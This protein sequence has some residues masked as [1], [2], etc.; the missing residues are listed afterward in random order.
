[1]WKHLH[2]IAVHPTRSVPVPGYNDPRAAIEREDA[3]GDRMHSQAPIDA[4]QKKPLSISTYSGAVLISIPGA[5][6]P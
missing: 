6:H 1:M 4:M 3:D 5:P 2:G